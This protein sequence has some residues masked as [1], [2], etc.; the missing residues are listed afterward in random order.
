MKKHQHVLTTAIILSG[1]A[2]MAANRAFPDSSQVEY[3]P[4]TTPAH[5][6]SDRPAPAEL[7]DSAQASSQLLSNTSIGQINASIAAIQCGES[8]VIVTSSC[9][10]DY[11]FNQN[12]TFIN[13]TTRR[14]RSLNYV[15]FM[16]KAAIITISTAAC[17]KAGASNY[18]LL[19]Q[20]DGGN[21]TGC[22]WFDV[23]TPDGRY[24]G[25]SAGVTSE[26]GSGVTSDLPV[27]QRPLRRSLEKAI[28]AQYQQPTSTVD[29]MGK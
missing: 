11:C 17:V 23:F 25:T 15:H 27:R 2:S 18:V 3:A 8:D 29:V 22:E 9:T 4:I 5:Q 16:Q 24:L 14:T 28:F 21:C 26:P 10:S 12:V 6:P 20:H 19:E 13:R 1:L 7:N